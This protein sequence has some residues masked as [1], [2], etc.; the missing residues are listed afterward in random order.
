MPRWG[1]GRPQPSWESTSRRRASI[2]QRGGNEGDLPI[3]GTDPL[4][5]RNVFQCKYR[6][7]AERASGE[8]IQCAGTF[9]AAPLQAFCDTL[10]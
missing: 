6:E 7:L 3:S 4:V 10:Q 5:P 8:A 9:T 2:V 1:C